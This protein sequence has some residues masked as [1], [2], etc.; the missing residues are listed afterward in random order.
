MKKLLIRLIVNM[1]S[2]AEQMTRRSDFDQHTSSSISHLTLSRSVEIYEVVLH[3]GIID[4]L[5]DYDI[6]K[7]LEHA[8]KSFQVDPTSILAVDLKLYSK[9]FHNFIGRTFI[10]DRCGSLVTRRG[11]QSDP[12]WVIFFNII[13]FLLFINKSKFRIFKNFRGIKY[14]YSFY[15]LIKLQYRTIGSI[16]NETKI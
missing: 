10:E 3:F 2:R 6:N 4:I 14:F 12:R 15:H 11:S 5:Q 1:P 13:I 16:W 7:K 8:Y 9:R